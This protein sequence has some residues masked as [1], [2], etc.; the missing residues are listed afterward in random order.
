[1]MIGSGLVKS[2]GA[3]GGG[4]PY[5]CNMTAGTYVIYTGYVAGTTG[6]I[7]A[8]PVTDETLLYVLAVGGG[9]GLIAFVGDLVTTLSGLTVWIDS[10]E[11]PPASDWTYDS[12]NDA[13][14]YSIGGTFP[15]LVDAE[16][17]LIEIK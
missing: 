2:L 5:S 13:T 4:G 8:E 14:T 15:D 9:S 6:S 16:T 10:V 3:G 12:E 17:Y 11:Y 7:D 1:M